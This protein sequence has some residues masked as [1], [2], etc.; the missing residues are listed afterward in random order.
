M[1][2]ETRGA[3]RRRSLATATAASARKASSNFELQQAALASV[4]STRTHATSWHL[5]LP[6]SRP[7]AR[8]LPAASTSTS[9]LAGVL[10]E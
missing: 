8:A 5:A 3:A 1:I 6:L 2:H 7:L 4:V 10:Y 9:A